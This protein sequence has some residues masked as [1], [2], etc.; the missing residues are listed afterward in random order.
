MTPV[1]AIRTSRG[2]APMRFA[3]ISTTSRASASPVGPFAT[4]AFLEMTTTPRTDPSV[5]FSLLTTTL[6]PAKRLFVNTPA[7]V[8]SSSAAMTTTSSEE[9][10]MPMLAT[11]AVKPAGSDPPEEV[12]AVIEH[13]PRRTGRRGAGGFCRTPSRLRGAPRGRGDRSC[14]AARSR[15]GVALFVPVPDVHSVSTR[16]A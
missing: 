11:V 5:R 3:V 9:S 13:P 8:Q 7:A 16:R 10:L 2:L 6:G 14:V 15:H 12:R 4:F 1:E